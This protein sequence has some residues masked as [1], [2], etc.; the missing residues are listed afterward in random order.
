MNKLN[1]T[2]NRIK[3]MH[4]FKQLE[5]IFIKSKTN[6]ETD[7]EADD[8]VDNEQPDTT[9]MPALDS[10]ESA[11]QKR[12]KKG[13][14]LKELTPDQMLSRLLSLAQLNAGNNSENLKMRQESYY[15]L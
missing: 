8:E 14:G 13:H 6:N 11:E 9:S 10:E 15:T 2:K 7:D 1:P 12:N 5:E 4:I 3:M